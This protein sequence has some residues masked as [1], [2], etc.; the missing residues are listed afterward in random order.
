M[1]KKIKILNYKFNNPITCLTAYSSPVAKIL[2]GNVDM[3]LIGDSLGTT[4][5]GMKNTRGVDIE[6]MKRHGLAV[7][8]YVKK[9]LTIIDMPYNTYS[10]TK[11]AYDNAKALLKFTRANLLKLEINNNIS[12]LEY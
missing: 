3:I 6:M 5:Y 12:I 7:T 4:L 11:E 1:K 2:D 9:S 10:E 8:K